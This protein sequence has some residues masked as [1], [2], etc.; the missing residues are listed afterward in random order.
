MIRRMLPSMI[1]WVLIQTMNKHS[2]KSNE[3][4]CN[5]VEKK[6]GAASWEIPG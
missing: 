1:R 5:F 6:P 4:S 3:F 2:V